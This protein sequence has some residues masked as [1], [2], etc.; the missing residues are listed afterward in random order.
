MKIKTVNMPYEEVLKLKKPAHQNPCKP[1][2]LLSTV[3]RLVAIPDLSAT[4]FKYTKKDMEKA[5]DGPWLILMNH[6]SFLDLEI[7]SKIMYPKTYNIVCTTDGF[8]GKP[9]LMQNLGCIPTNKFVPDMQ[10]ISDISY[11]IKKNKTNVLMY[12]E[13]SYS[14]DGRATRLPRG[15]GILF[16][17]LGIPIVMV[18]TYGSFTRDP[19]YNSLQK[20]KVVV[21]AEM[22]CLLTPEECKTLKASE[23]DDILDKA[24]S[25]DYFKWQQ[26]NNITINESFRADGLNRILYKC[27]CCKTEGQT[28]GKGT[29]FVCHACGKEYELDEKGFINAVNGETE[30]NHIPDWNSWQRSEVRK[31]IENGTYN[32]ELDV[33][34]G[35]LV[36]YKAIYM[37][38]SGKLIHNENGFTLTA[39]DG[40]LNY[41]QS[42]TYA[43]STYSDFFWY[44]I[45]DIICIGDK[46]YIYYC[47][48]K[49]KDVVSKIRMAAEE[50]YKLKKQ[51][52]EQ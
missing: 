45:G 9:W 24:F 26:E 12:P 44:E 4:H 31:E 37:V 5:G 50:M 35:M 34:V 13:A 40:K 29:K 18:T 38:G 49:E 27:P 1:S 10:L 46:S 52:Q 23:I 14:F 15:L 32:M 30:F 39:C 7:I 3:E 33:E 20:R 6:S 42:P 21:S 19:L 36:D 47:F 25:F 17:R 22:R 51:T 48:P 16:K 41:E 43:Y 11:A 2:F 28:E 8:V